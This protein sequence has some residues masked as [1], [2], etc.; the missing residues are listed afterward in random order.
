MKERTD[1]LNLIKIKASALWKSISRELEE[2]PQSGEKLLAKDTSDKGL[3]SKTCKDFLILCNKKTNNPV[4]KWAKILTDT[5]PKKIHRWQI[6][7][8]KEAPHQLSSGKCKLKQD[9]TTHLLEWPKSG[10]PTTSNAGKGV[11][12]QELSYIAGGN[13]KWY[14]RFGRQLADSYRM[15]QLWSLVFT[16]SWNYCLHKNLHVMFIEDFHNCPN[17][18]ATSMSFSRWMNK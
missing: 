15:Q 8:E 2:K 10:T 5:S 12:Q 11:E 6:S 18:E 14:S 1:E 9:T 16:Q 17:S 13:A 7:I 4:R 3:L